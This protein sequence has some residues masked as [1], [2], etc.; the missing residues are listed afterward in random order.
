MS[1]RIADLLPLLA[2]IAAGLA[3]LV[4]SATAASHVDLILAALVLATALD[5]DPRQLLGIAGHVRALVL[6]AGVPMLVLGACAWALAQLVHGQVH[7]GTLA[8]GLAPAEVA[9][10]GLIGLMGGASELAIAVLT[11]SLALSAVIGPPAL[12]LLGHAPKGAGVAPLLGRFAL[13]VIVPLAVGL[14]GRGALPGLARR[15]SALS[16]ASSLLVAGLI[17]A[18]L[19]ATHASQL[20]SALLVSLAFLVVSALLAAIA[21]KAFGRRLEPSLALTIG[22]RDFAVAAALA[23]ATFGP[24]AAQ[25]AGVYGTLMLI[26]GATATSLVRSRR[27]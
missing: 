8:L 19:S 17:F 18:S 24:Q 12:V 21:V 7:N 16:A 14:L 10:V 3:L 2:L 9:S 15:K 25:V 11:L 27:R 26:A 4:P 20:G 23:A 1:D 22:M 13:V 5:I 6:L